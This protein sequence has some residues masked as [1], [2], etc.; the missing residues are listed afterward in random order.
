MAARPIMSSDWLKFQFVL[1]SEIQDICQLG[2]KKKEQTL[3]EYS[4][5]GSLPI[6]FYDDPRWPPL[7]DIV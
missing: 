7:Q 1:R 4:F 6:I 3:L 5:N 2:H